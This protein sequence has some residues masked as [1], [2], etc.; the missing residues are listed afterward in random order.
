MVVIFLQDDGYEE[1]RGAHGGAQGRM[2]RQTG[3]PGI[4]QMGRIFQIWPE[5]AKTIGGRLPR[6][7]IKAS[8]VG[9]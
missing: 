4:S 7:G 3:R 6:F 1:G 5:I 8:V 2:V 9:A